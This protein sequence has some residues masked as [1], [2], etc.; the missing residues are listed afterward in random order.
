MKKVSILSLHLGYGGIEKCVVSLANMLCKQYEVEIACCYQLYDQSAFHLDERV[1]VNYL[2]KPDII[3]NRERFNEALSSKKYVEV[4]KEGIVSLKVLFYR[5]YSMIK[6]IRN[7][8]ADYIISTR[9]IFNT[10][11][12]QFAKKG[13]IKIGWEHNHPHGDQK[14][15]KKVANSAKHLNY[16]IA[17]S[18][19]LQK[20]YA[21][22]VSCTC[23]YI[24]NCID[25]L[26]LQPSPLNVS[27]LVSVGRLSP[28]KG[29]LDLLKVYALLHNQ[30]RDWVLDIIGDGQEMNLLNEY[31]H[32][33]LITDYVTLHGFQNK[34]Y[35]DSVMQQSSIYVMCSHTESFG[36]VLIEAMSHGIPCIAFDSAEGA[37]E[38]IKNGENGYLIPN[39][40]FNAMVQKIHE[41]I[42]NS[43]LRVKMGQVARTTAM[44]YSSDVVEKQWF[45][46]LEQEVKK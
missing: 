13:I 36:I 46:L 31:I 42:S 35:I 8:D 11:S 21:S 10:W 7:C 22:M 3:P 12:G 34:E 1:K 16:F 23:Y 14:F 39:R 9:D 29:F 32:L 19:E 28:E 41:L 6:Y 17:V 26:P 40:D 15:A 33:N 43:E 25:Q 2:N 37:R 30:D 24:P 4:L 5:Q 18:P 44:Q 27:R 38:I 20:F 45:A